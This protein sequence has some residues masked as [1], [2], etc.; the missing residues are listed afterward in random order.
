VLPA[1]VMVSR[2]IPGA[3]RERQGQKCPVCLPQGTG[4]AHL[5]QLAWHYLSFYI[6]EPSD[7]DRRVLLSYLPSCQNGTNLIQH[8]SRNLSRTPPPNSGKPLSS[9]WPVEGAAG[10][11]LTEGLSVSVPSVL[12]IA[13]HGDMCKS[14]YLFESPITSVV[15]TGPASEVAFVNLMS[16]H[17]RGIWHV[18]SQQTFPSLS[19][20][21]LPVLLSSSCAP[22]HLVT[23]RRLP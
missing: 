23:Q 1:W 10:G 11:S 3:R 4:E 20:S 15:M 8:P 16:T 2:K 17:M 9:T 7:E 18:G 5:S 22:P 14:L 12:A 21:H 19:F 6:P 13:N